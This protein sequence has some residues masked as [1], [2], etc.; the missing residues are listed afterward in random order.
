ML[1][2]AAALA[3]MFAWSDLDGRLNGAGEAPESESHTVS[4]IVRRDFGE[5]AAGSF[6]V[7][8][9]APSTRW[10]SPAFV[11]AV[12]ASV[13]RAARAAAG[14]SSPLLNVSPRVAYAAL[15]TELSAAATTKRAAAI[16]QAAGQVPGARVEISGFPIVTAELSSVI[17]HDL[18]R[19]EMVAIP[20]TAVILLLLFGSIPA[21]AVPLL[22]AL[23]TISVAI[24][25]VWIEAAFVEIPVYAT[26]VVTLVGIALA[27]DYSMLYVSR[28][29]EEVRGGAPDRA[30]PLYAT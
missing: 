11:K 17:T 18:R 5:A 1:W 19:A 25:I 12:R 22:F 26:S 10:H 30:H 4:E 27:V 21:V 3:G 6:L 7:L 13:R 28:Y 2:A 24:G 29:R 8:Y 15:P 16:E 9:E 14:R 20:I 23:A